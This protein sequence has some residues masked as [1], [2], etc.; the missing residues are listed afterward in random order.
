MSVNGAAACGR[1]E[2]VI[3][4]PRSRFGG[5][6][7]GTAIALFSRGTLAPGAFAIAAPHKTSD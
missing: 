3:H 1:A 2:P 6:M 7:D 5:R 4:A